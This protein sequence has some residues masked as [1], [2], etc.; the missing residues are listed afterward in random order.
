MQHSGLMACLVIK[1]AVQITAGHIPKVG[2][3]LRECTT[4]ASVVVH[5]RNF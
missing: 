2:L 4:S 1:C 3:H 5:L